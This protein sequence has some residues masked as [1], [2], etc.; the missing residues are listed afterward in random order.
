[1]PSKSNPFT[2]V[3]HTLY[4]HSAGSFYERAW[5]DG[6]QKW[7][8]LH[9]LTLKDARL[10]VA[11]RRQQAARF[12][13]GLDRDPYL[14]TKRIEL[15]TLLDDYAA[16]KFPD[17]KGRPRPPV[18]A[19]A[20]AYRLPKLKEFFGRMSAQDL[21][22]KTFTDY[23]RFRSKPRLPARSVDLELWTLQNAVEFARRNGLL[24]V[25]TVRDRPRFAGRPLRNARDRM[26]GNAKVLHELAQELLEN[27]RSQ[28]L[29]WQMLIGAL[30]GLRTSELLRLRMKAEPQKAG[31]I[32]S[33]ALWLDRSKGGV[34]PWVVIHADLDACL[35]AHRR[36]HK[37]TCRKSPWWF[38]GETPARTVDKGALTHALHRL[39]AERQR[40]A[41]TP[42]GLRAY[43][44]TVRRSQGISD[45]QIA[46]EIGD[47]TGASIVAEVYGAVPPNWQGFP[48]LAWTP[49]KMPPAWT[50]WLPA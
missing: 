27:P 29:G 36:W 49:D 44:V 18:S 35:R 22:W 26:P 32:D 43:F 48:G 40:P 9:A 50:P 16:A 15:A 45:A 2:R 10:E 33:Q 37:L 46:A 41:V 38:P 19:K 8:R 24:T 17:R 12:R 20:E 3:D 34:N 31:Y 7:K 11:K 25:N 23:S 13:A 42:H 5:I 30:T 39:T 1:M 21:T 14:D 6:R 28:V 4:R 47:K